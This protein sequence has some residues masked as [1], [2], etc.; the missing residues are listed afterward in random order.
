MVYMWQLSSQTSNRQFFRKRETWNTPLLLPY[1]ARVRTS[2]CFITPR[3][4]GSR[5][6]GEKH[7]A[8]RN[9]EK[10]ASHAGNRTRIGRVRACYPNQLDYMGPVSSRSATFMKAAPVTNPV[11]FACYVGYLCSEIQCCAF[12]LLSRSPDCCRESDSR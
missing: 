5:E 6:R 11:S 9:E 10:R 12:L 8:P 2:L 1:C 4:G 7:N 3:G